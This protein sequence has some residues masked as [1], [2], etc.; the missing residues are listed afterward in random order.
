MALLRSALALLAEMRTLGIEPSLISY[1]TAISA[2][3]WGQWERALSLLEEM[4][5]RGIEPDV[6]SYT[7]LITAY[8]NAEP[9]AE[10]DEVGPIT[11]K[12]LRGRDAYCLRRVTRGVLLAG[13]VGEGG[14]RRRRLPLRAEEEALEGPQP[15]GE[16]SGHPCVFVH[17][18][19]EGVLGGRERVCR[20]PPK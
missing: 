16:P 14:R 11:L 3:R 17:I 20:A 6:L 10:W 18:N 13:G 12:V 15:R 9:E 4:S 8:A 1:N 7:G 5:S 2:C 19:K